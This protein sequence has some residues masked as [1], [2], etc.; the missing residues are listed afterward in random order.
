MFV[1]SRARVG[2]S[3]YIFQRPVVNRMIPLQSR[4]M[5]T[6]DSSDGWLSSLSRSI[7]G[8]NTPMGEPSP[9]QAVIK[10]ELRVS[11]G[12]PMSLARFMELGL[13]HP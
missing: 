6:Q 2:L 9:L 10:N 1:A 12:V 11:G 5:S 4:F 3:G 7:Q 8:S 13:Q